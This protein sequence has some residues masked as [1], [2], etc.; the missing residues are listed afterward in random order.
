MKLEQRQGEIIRDPAAL[1]RTIV[2]ILLD[3]KGVDTLLL[4]V[5]EISLLADYFIISTG[6]VD[7]QIKAIAEEISQTLK[8]E[9]ILPLHVEGDAESGWVL[10]DY[11]EIVVHL[12]SPEMRSFYR[13]EELWKEARVVVKVQ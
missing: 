8:S 2:D 12:L 5:R 3:K 1:A 6:E 11:G 13:L 10:M 4:D 7:R 9:H